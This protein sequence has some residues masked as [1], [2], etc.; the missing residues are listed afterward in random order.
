MEQ[1][2]RCNTKQQYKKGGKQSWQIT[3][4]IEF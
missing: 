1:T 4:E 2:Y 3:G